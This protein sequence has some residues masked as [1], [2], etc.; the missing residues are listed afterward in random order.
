MKPAVQSDQKKD[1]DISHNSH[2]VHGQEQDKEG[3]LNPPVAW[4]PQQ[5]ELT[6]P[7]LCFIPL[8]HLVSKNWT[9]DVKMMN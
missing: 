5:N 1:E 6:H 3:D 2:Q 7:C 4:E 9:K 8:T